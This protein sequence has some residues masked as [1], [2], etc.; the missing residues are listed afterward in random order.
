MT[1]FELALLAFGTIV[2]SIATILF[3]RMKAAY[4]K[5][6]IEPYEEDGL[7]GMYKI[8]IGVYPNQNIPSKDMIILCRD[9]DDSW[10]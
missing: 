6:K 1:L 2:G 7:T 10:E 4:G 9:G 8:K 5:F 3:S